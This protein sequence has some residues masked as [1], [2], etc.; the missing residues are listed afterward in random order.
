MVHQQHGLGEKGASGMSSQSS[1][2]PDSLFMDEFCIAGMCYQNQEMP[3]NVETPM[4]A[5]DTA[6]LWQVNLFSQEMRITIDLTTF[7]VNCKTHL[8]DLTLP[9]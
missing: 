8:S 7:S 6:L 2:L 1:S 9:H 4:K 5:E 3:T